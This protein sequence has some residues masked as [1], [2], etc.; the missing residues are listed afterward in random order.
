MG[1][2]G[3]YCH[4]PAGDSGAD[5]GPPDTGERWRGR[6]GFLKSRS[7]RQCL[8]N[9]TKIV[10]ATAGCENQKILGKIGTARDFTR[11]V[12]RVPL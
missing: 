12:R 2:I 6:S 3:N 7:M 10:G 11:T 1:I 8:W 9:V 5:R 4:K